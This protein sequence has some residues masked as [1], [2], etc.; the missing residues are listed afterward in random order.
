MRKGDYHIKVDT[1]DDSY[2]ALNESGKTLGAS[3][4]NMGT[5]FCGNLKLN[6]FEMLETSGVHFLD[7]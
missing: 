4:E 7:F 2:F 6:I 3:W 1:K 5:S